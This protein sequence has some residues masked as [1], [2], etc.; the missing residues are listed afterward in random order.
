VIRAFFFLSLPLYLS[1]Y[2]FL[3]PLEWI[4]R[5]VVYK[6]PTHRPPLYNL[7]RETLDRAAKGTPKGRHSS[8]F[9][10]CSID[11]SSLNFLRHDFS[12]GEA[13]RSIFSTFSAAGKNIVRSMRELRISSIVPFPISRII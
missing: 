12:A 5:E 6:L 13:V 1:F 2:I 9:D 4:N 10:N 8:I 7:F 11:P 3:C